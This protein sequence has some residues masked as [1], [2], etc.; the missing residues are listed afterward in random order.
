[1]AATISATPNETIFRMTFR[2]VFGEEVIKTTVLGGAIDDEG[3]ENIFNNLDA[4]SNAAIVNAKVSNSRT[5]TGLKANPLN[6][7]ERNVSNQLVL[8]FAKANPLN[9]SAPFVNKSFIIPAYVA[10]V[11][12]TE[13][14]EIIADL[15]PT[16]S[17]APEQLGNLINVLADNLQYQGAN[18]TYY[19]GDWLWDVAASGFGTV[20][21]VIDGQ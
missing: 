21:N 19:P 15:T 12:N 9:A 4:L 2:D 10:S 3:I 18:G 6:A 5:V 7:L 8:T 17:T 20:P 11:Q 13:T 16:G 14:N 1:M